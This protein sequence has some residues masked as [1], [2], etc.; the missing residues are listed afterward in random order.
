MKWLCGGKICNKPQPD[1][2]IHED[3]IYSK[4]GYKIH[5]CR[6]KRAKDIVQGVCPLEEDILE[7]LRTTGFLLPLYENNKLLI[8]H[9]W[10]SDPDWEIPLWP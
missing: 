10:V 8:Y 3:G 6:T 1:W 4:D 7:G 5:R 9:A 2:E